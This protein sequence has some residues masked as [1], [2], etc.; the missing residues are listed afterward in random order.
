M[1]QINTPR[2]S[3]GW[4]KIVLNIGEDL[5]DLEFFNNRKKLLSSAKGIFFDELI[6]TIDFNIEKEEYYKRLRN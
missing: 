6:N 2:I 4:V 1:F 3:N 5:Y